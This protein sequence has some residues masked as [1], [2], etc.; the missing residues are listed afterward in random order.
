MCMEFYLKHHPS[1]HPP[2][3][4]FLSEEGFGI[5][6]VCE[7]RMVTKALFVAQMFHFPPCLEKKVLYIESIPDFRLFE[8][9]ITR[10][11]CVPNHVYVSVLLICDF[12]VVVNFGILMLLLIWDIVPYRRLVLFSEEEITA[13]AHVTYMKVVPP[14]HPPVA[15]LSCCLFF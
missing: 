12:V 13:R 11:V 5:V 10:N 14:P 8:S 2:T 1:T 4:R 3:P 7:K 9:V 15:F 6:V